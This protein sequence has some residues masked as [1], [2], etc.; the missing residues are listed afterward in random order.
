MK[1]P[2]KI[3]DVTNM[4]DYKGFTIEKIMG[5]YI[6]VLYGCLYILYIG[7]QGGW[8][9]VE[10]MSSARVFRTTKFCHDL[11]DEIL[12]DHAVWVKS[13][14]GTPVMELKHQKEELTNKKNEI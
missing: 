5:G 8:H 12:V 6:I 7:G 2:E 9:M 4:V 13:L 10:N 14:G 11:I 3:V 1:D